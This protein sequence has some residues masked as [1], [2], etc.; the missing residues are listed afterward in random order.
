MHKSLGFTLIELLVVVLIIGILSAI[1]LPQYQMAVRKARMVEMQTLTKA[2]KNAQEIYYMA[3]GFYTRDFYELDIN[4]PAGLSQDDSGNLVL[5]SGTK[6]LVLDPSAGSTN[7]V[8]AINTREKLGFTW[9][10]DKDNP[11]SRAGKQFCVAYADETSR[12]LCRSISNGEGSSSC[13]GDGITSG[14][15]SYEVF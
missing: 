7:R 8:Y 11:S 6:L 1:A 2:I 14:C 3:N 4:P 12:R 9:Y 10:M 5:P 15:M 13:S